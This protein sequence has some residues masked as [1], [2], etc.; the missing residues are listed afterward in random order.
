MNKPLI[1]ALLALSLCATGCG[2]SVSSAAP[3]KNIRVYTEA[4]NYL[5]IPVPQ[6]ATLV[7]TDGM[8]YWDYLDKEGN[9]TTVYKML[10]TT[11]DTKQASTLHGKYTYGVKDSQYRVIE[12]RKALNAF[13]EKQTHYKLLSENA[14]TLSHN[15]LPD[16]TLSDLG[17]LVPKGTSHKEI[18]AYSAMT[19]TDGAGEFFTAYKRLA[20][21]DEL[22]QE[23]LAWLCAADADYKA[24]EVLWYK[25]DLT[26]YAKS[27]NVCV[28]LRALTT[29][30]W[31]AF[32]ASEKY[33]PYL[34]NNLVAQHPK[35]RGEL[36]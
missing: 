34:E 33:R 22:Q 28:G 24:D 14:V 17:L 25:D 6:S 5:E 19:T 23:A 26:L 8:S 20:K 21:Y 27:H 13:K 3:T 10:E 16:E 36:T 15:D 32:Y 31:A 11:I 12:A 35:G 7:R 18:F 30:N 29:N 1:I 4:T 9:K 2:H